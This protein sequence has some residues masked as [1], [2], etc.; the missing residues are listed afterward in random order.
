MSFLSIAKRLRARFAASW[1]DEEEDP[2]AQDSP[3]V[4][5]DDA[6]PS[7]PAQAASEQDVTTERMD[8]LYWHPQP[9]VVI[10]ERRIAR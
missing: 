5:T 3:L 10:E 2:A 6:P 8:H 1:Q 4:E 7:A 9:S